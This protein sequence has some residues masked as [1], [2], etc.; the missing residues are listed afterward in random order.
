MYVQAQV[1]LFKSISANAATVGEGDAA[2][3]AAAGDDDAAAA[4]GGGRDAKIEPNLRL[5]LNTDTANSP[6]PPPAA[7][8]ASAAPAAEAAEEAA[9]PPGK[10]G[11]VRAVKGA[12]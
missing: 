6:T 8:A 11:R 10:R 5:E 9:S 4:G 3:T 12:K 1:Q 2:A 7:T